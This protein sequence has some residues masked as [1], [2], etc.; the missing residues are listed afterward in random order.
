MSVTWR[1]IVPT[2]SPSKDLRLHFNFL[3]LHFDLQR[4]HFDLQRLHF[5]LRST[6]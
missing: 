4:L 1:P 5:D 2:T 6:T 3:R